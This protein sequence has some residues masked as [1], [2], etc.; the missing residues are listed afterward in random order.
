M[1]RKKWVYAVLC[2]VLVCL[3]FAG[4][5]I[6]PQ[7]STPNQVLK[8]YY[9]NQKYTIRF[10]TEDLE[11]KLSPLTYTASRTTKLPTVS[12]AGYVFAGWYYDRELKEECN[13]SNLKLKMCDVVLYP[14]W[15]KQELRDNGIYKLEFDVIR[16]KEDPVTKEELTDEYPPKEFSESIIKGNTVIEKNGQQKILKIGY[17]CGT[18]VPFGSKDPYTLELAKDKNPKGMR[19]VKRTENASESKKEVYIDISEYED[20]D[21][22]IYLSVTAIN[23]LTP[24]M[25]SDDRIKTTTTYIVKFKIKVIKGLEKE[26]SKIKNGK[27]HDGHYLVRTFYRQMD[28]SSTMMSYFN[29]VYGYLIAKDGHYK[30]VKEVNP[31]YGLFA[32]EADLAE[33]KNQNFFNRA[34]TFANFYAAYTIDFNANEPMNTEEHHNKIESKYYPE[35]YNGGKFIE[36][37]LEY[38]SQSNK[39]WQ[40]FDLGQSLG[41][42]FAAV[43]AVTG[44]MELVMHMG[45]LEQ[46]MTIDY[47][48]IVAV[49]PEY[50][51][52]EGDAYTF[53]RETSH[54]AGNDT[55]ILNQGIAK[56]KLEECG[57]ASEYLNFLFSNKKYFSNKELETNKNIRGNIPS[58]RVTT[59]GMT[60]DEMK[61][62]YTKMQMIDT[63]YEVFGFDK[64]QYLY[65]DFM[66]TQT[67]GSQG[68]RTI[69]PVMSGTMLN[70]G[71][72][73]SIKEIFKSKVDKN[74]SIDFVDVKAYKA[75]YY[76]TDYSQEISLSGDSYTYAEPVDLIYEY[77]KNGYKRIAKV[78]L[79]TYEEPDFNLNARPED[80]FS[81]THEYMPGE[82]YSIPSK[83]TAMWG[84]YINTYVAKFYGGNNV[85]PNANKFSYNLTLLSRYEEKNG[86]MRH[87]ESIVEEY[88]KLKIPSDT[89][90]VVWVAEIRNIFGERKYKEIKLQIKPAPR[91]IIKNSDGEEVVNKASRISDGEIK[92]ENTELYYIVQTEEDLKKFIKEIYTYQVA[93]K[94]GTFRLE[95]Y[96]T[97]TGSFAKDLWKMNIDDVFNEINGLV[98]DGAGLTLWY[99]SGSET[100]TVKIAAFVT[101]NGEQDVKVSSHKA[102]FTNQKYK[103]EFAKIKNKNG[104]R[105]TTKTTM[106]V[107]YMNGGT[108]SSDKAHFEYNDIT[109]EIIFKQA[110][111]YYF[112]YYFSGKNFFFSKRFTHEVYR[113]DIDVTVRYTT[114]AAHPFKDGTTEKEI[115]HS[116][117]DH[118]LLMQAQ[119]YA[120]SIPKESKL[121]GYTTDSEEETG[122]IGDGEKE[123]TNFIHRFHSREVTLHAVWDDGKLI[124]LDM[125]TARTGIPNYTRRMYKSGSTSQGY[126]F[127]NQTYGHQLNIENILKDK[128]I[129]SAAQIN[130]L[131]K[132]Y[133]L[134]ELESDVFPGGSIS[135]ETYKKN[136]MYE[137]EEDIT[138]K[139]KFR[140]RM[141]LEYKIDKKDDDN[142]DEVSNTYLA[143]ADI[144][145]G[146]VL[147]E[148]LY[149][150]VEI[151]EKYKDKYEFLGW[152]LFGDSTETL[153]DFKTYVPIENSSGKLKIVAKIKRK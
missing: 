117:K 129:F 63:Q 94:S 26:Y 105:I 5:T 107:Y 13:D 103:L 115:T 143:N 54:Y 33:P 121:L 146:E 30:Y 56:S 61:S 1:N 10:N 70:P 150:K 123:I 11:D 145:A 125:D 59:R 99:S 82:T 137:F 120:D 25:S 86:K 91:Y 29:P 144:I 149:K 20:Y 18:T 49:A 32:N 88:E 147:G 52:L 14:K 141:K 45:R 39:M 81:E 109:G 110:G 43:G 35:K 152:H 57:T 142:G 151:K 37:S 64:D 17:D 50:K 136:V 100:I 58:F 133:K 138:I 73:A 85:N 7:N 93:H 90:S 114:D 132:N 48:N 16:S 74:Q 76:E 27:L 78:R 113:H 9:G 97:S 38:D 44:F 95:S 4:C 96:R 12:K 46:I 15:L 106:Q 2:I 134:V 101:F 89:E 72:V 84:G 108:Y 3:S 24:G 6:I 60:D 126:Y 102:L 124:T 65:G 83:M 66:S 40:I 130:S 22:P 80:N 68:R 42:H 127:A 128:T 53:R 71:D 112:V 104:E 36:Y 34:T 23:Y 98:K 8:K 92:S 41:K 77:L 140:R 47:D 69:E 79:R 87:E 31:Y 28:N 131:S 62:Q 19:I 75:K 67:F 153:I 21:K 119:D 122:T 116:L 51:S 111:K 139:L 118:L 148:D 55:S 135:I